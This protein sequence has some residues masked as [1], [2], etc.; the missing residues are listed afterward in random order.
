MIRLTGEYKVLSAPAALNEAAGSL[1]EKA[2]LKP[3]IKRCFCAQ[4]RIF[5]IVFVLIDKKSV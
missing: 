3:E 4:Q 1:K 2:S 5:A